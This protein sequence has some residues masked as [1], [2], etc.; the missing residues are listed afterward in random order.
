MDDLDKEA[1]ELKEHLPSDVSTDTLSTELEILT[2]EYKVPLEY[3]KESII[4]DYV[5]EVHSLSRPQLREE[6]IAKYQEKFDIDLSNIDS[7]TLLS[8]NYSEEV[9]KHVFGTDS[10]VSYDRYN[11]D[12]VAEAILS[13]ESTNVFV[14]VSYNNYGTRGIVDLFI[15]DTNETQIIELKSPSAIESSTGANE[16]IR[17]FNKMRKNFFSGDEP[18]P[19]PLDNNTFI[20]GFAPTS[21]CIK[22]LLENWEIY[23][24]ARQ[25]S[26]VYYNTEQFETLDQVETHIGIYVPLDTTE[27][28]DIIDLTNEEGEVDFSTLK[29]TLLQHSPVLHDEVWPAVRKMRQ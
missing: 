23:L 12:K 17:Q 13:N 9:I 22:H 14:E 26:D 27:F 11:E 19:A 2:Q 7:S 4:N 20:L 6:V 1:K 21:T 3:A 16:I 15:E 10:F 24:S 8:E 28:I 25:T 5:P 29:L 18:F